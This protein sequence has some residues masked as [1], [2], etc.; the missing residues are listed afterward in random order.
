MIPPP[1]GLL[2]VAVIVHD[3]A[4]NVA[5]KVFQHSHLAHIN[6]I[7]WTAVE[8]IPPPFDVNRC[9]TADDRQNICVNKGRGGELAP[10]NLAPHRGGLVEIQTAMATTTTQQDCCHTTTSLDRCTPSIVKIGRIQ[11]FASR[12]ETT[13]NV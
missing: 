11:P 13:M 1:E 5:E 3:P 6:D 8:T 4:R 12:H 9:E 7:V 2:T 10:P